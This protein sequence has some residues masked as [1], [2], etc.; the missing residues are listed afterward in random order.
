MQGNEQAVTARIEALRTRFM[1]RCLADAETFSRLSAQLDSPEDS[2]EARI[3]A[4]SRAHR[5]AGSGSVFGF[6]DLS[7][8][9]AELQQHLDTDCADRE[10]AKGIRAL[11]D[12]IRTSIASAT[13][14]DRIASGETGHSPGS[15]R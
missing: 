12:H 9:A 8:H 4:R 11:T 13:G 1:E 7:E 3:E 6:E 5:L 10:A 14:D 2:G 15:N